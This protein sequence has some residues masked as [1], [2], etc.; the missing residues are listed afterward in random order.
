VSGI[1]FPTKRRIFSY[2]GDYRLVPEP[3]LVNI[4]MGEIT[5][6]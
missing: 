6:S 3:L 1:I 4:D 2:E 5:V